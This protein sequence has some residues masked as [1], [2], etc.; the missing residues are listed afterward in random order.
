LV[1]H[2]KAITHTGSVR[3]QDT[4][5]GIFLTN[6]KEVTGDWRKPHNEKHHDD[7]NC[8]PNSIQIIKS[9]GIRWEGHVAC[10]G[11]KKD[12]SRVMVWKTWRKETDC[13]TKA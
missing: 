3:E 1:P 8:S 12:T 5:E 2:I 4:E 7:L 13:K 9:R 10:S 6:R 11:Q